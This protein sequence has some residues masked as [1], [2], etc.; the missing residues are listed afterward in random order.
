MNTQHGAPETPQKPF[1]AFPRASG[2]RTLA[3]TV[4]GDAQPAGSKRGF[5]NHKTGAVI[6]TDANR[7]AKP[8][9]QEVKAA[10]MEALEVDFPILRGPVELTL[11]FIR[12][13]PK[14]HFGTGRNSQLV[15]SSAPAF[16]ITRPDALKL[17]RGVEDALTGLVYADDSQIVDE[18]LYKRYGESPRCEIEVRELD[19]RE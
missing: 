12:A 14:A 15:K 17:A 10:A 19:A 2:G 7:K 16:P 9:Q 11:T 5:V 4:H 13:R 3:F 18:H 8:W 6:V 1:C